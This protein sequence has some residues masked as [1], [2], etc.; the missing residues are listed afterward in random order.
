M[1]IDL[2]TVASH[3]GVIA[4]IVGFAFLVVSVNL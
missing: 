1:S 2:P 3:A 4:A